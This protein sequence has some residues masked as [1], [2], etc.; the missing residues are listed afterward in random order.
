[1][2]QKGLHSSTKWAFVAGSLLVFLLA[3]L[4]LV[5]GRP[6]L[7]QPTALFGIPIGNLLAWLM[8][9][10]LPLTVWLALRTSGLR[11]P[12]LVLV[13]MGA[14]WLPVC[15]L[16]A[17][18]VYLNYSEDMPFVAS[19]IYSGFCMVLPLVLV[20][21]WSVVRLLARFRS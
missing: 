15:I 8:A 9:L 10:S 20:A 4:G 6:W 19:L 1:M 18:N 2:K 5:A 13:L 14:L 11:W 16:L 3:T 7:E 12:L 21:G 17:G